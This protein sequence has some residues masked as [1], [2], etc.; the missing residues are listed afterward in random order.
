MSAATVTNYFACVSLQAEMKLKKMLSK[1]KKRPKKED[2]IV[3]FNIYQHQLTDSRIVLCKLV[4]RLQAES[5]SN[6]NAEAD[7]GDAIVRAHIY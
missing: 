1:G 7:E 5:E 4:G 2:A 6:A 3:R